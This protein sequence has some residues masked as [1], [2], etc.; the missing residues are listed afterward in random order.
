MKYKPSIPSIVM[1]NVNSLT[2]KCD[3][4]EASVI[5]QQVYRECSLMCFS[6]SWLTKSTDDSC[7]DIPGFTAVR[8]DREFRTSG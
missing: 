7:V 3:E 4:L 1:G 6:E 8:A 5:N 2:N